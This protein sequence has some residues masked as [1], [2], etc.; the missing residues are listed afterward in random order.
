VIASL[1][2]CAAGLLAVWALAQP[3]PSPAQAADMR[4]RRPSLRMF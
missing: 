4:V 1:K 2:L 3:L